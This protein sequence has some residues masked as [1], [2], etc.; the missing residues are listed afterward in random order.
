MANRRHLRIV[1]KG[2]A[3]IAEWRESQPDARLDLSHA[4]LRG[5]DLSGAILGRAYLG[6]AYLAGADLSGANLGGVELHHADLSDADLGGANLRGANLSRANLRRSNLR[7]ANLSG[8]DLNHANLRRAILKVADLSGADLEKA[9][10]SAADLSGADLSEANLS[11]ASLRNAK[12]ENADLS[13][14]MVSPD[15]DGVSTTDFSGASLR[16]IRTTDPEDSTYNPGQGVLELALARGLDRAQFND[17]QLAE[18]LETAIGYALQSEISENEQGRDLVVRAIGK[19]R[20][21]RELYSSKDL[22]NEL[23]EVVQTISAELI[24]YLAA[25][26]AELHSLRPRQF[27]ELIAEI[28]ASY[29]WQVEL[30][31]ETRDGGYDIFGVHKDVAGV[32]HTWVIECKKY[33]PERKVG[34]DIVRGL[35]GITHVQEGAN[36]LLATTSDFSRDAWQYKASRYNLDFK[37]YKAILGWLN[38]YKPSP[39]GR[40][41]LR[42]NRL[43]VGDEEE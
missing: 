21:L 39:D 18:Y 32:A 29:G 35:Y 9:D 26:P 41:Y 8:V 5:A 28:L 12:L 37:N 2:T 30:S 27:E 34:V 17:G 24:K 42:D 13:L 20:A 33:A 15:W 36:A 25:H 7:R 43:V 31:P 40:L 23:A 4:D 6:R 16:G 22:P 10:L 1:R 11:G 38:A 14:I 3:A 19:I